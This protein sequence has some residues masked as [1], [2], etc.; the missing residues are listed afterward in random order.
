MQLNMGQGKSS[1]IVPLVIVALADNLADKSN[2]FISTNVQE[3]L[4]PETM[5]LEQR[6]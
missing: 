5:S 6:Y 3:Y 4:E 1:V 2:A